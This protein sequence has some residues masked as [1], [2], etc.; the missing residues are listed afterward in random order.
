[1]VSTTR[2]IQTAQTVAIP[3]KGQVSHV[4][5]FTKTVEQLITKAEKIG[6]LF[7]LP[8]KFDYPMISH[9]EYRRRMAESAV[10]MP[11]FYLCGDGDFVD[12]PSRT[13]DT[14][15][16]IDQDKDEYSSRL[17]CFGMKNEDFVPIKGTRY[18]PGVHWIWFYPFSNPGMSANDFWRCNDPGVLASIET[19]MASY[20]FPEWKR[21]WDGKSVKYPILGGMEFGGKVG[22]GEK[23]TFVLGRVDGD[24]THFT[25]IPA[26]M[27]SSL[28]CAPTYK[29]IG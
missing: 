8:I 28:Y 20:L 11:V 2:P 5:G 23:Q 7:N 3:F 26:S 4:P 22:S 24:R 16:R 10:L 14:L 15:R 19:M 6:Q 13:V 25:R 18:R 9:N 17:V 21:L 29:Q 1:M 27:K 12:G